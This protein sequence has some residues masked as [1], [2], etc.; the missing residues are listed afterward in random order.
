MFPGGGWDAFA[1]E[2]PEDF[3]AFLATQFPFG[4]LG[5]PQEVADADPAPQVSPAPHSSR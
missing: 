5:I 3:A 2:N 4:R 1:H